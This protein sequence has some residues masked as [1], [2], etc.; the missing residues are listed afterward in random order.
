MHT[1]EDRSTSKIVRCMVWE[2]CAVG[3]CI[4]CICAV[5]NRD[6]IAH[7]KSRKV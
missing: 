2:T 5:E 7:G 3:L 4:I 6:Y 1:T